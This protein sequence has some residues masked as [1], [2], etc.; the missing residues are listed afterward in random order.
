MNI[1]Y[2]I[3]KINEALQN[4]RNATGINI[5]MVKK[6]FSNI[7]PISYPNNSYCGAVQK[8]KNGAKRCFFSDNELY[9][10]CK[11]SRKMEMHVCHAGLIDVVVPIIYKN[12]IISYIILGQMK[13]DADFASV[14]NY[15]R[16]LD[17]DPD[18]MEKNYNSLYLFNEEKI[19][20]IAAVA[21]ML[22]KYILLENMLIPNTNPELQKAVDYINENLENP[23]KIKDI[24]KVSNLSKS[25]LY[26]RFH[27]NFNCTVIDYV[28]EKRVE[29][30]AEM[31]ERT[32]LSME[33]ISQKLGFSSKSYFSKIFK[34]K[35]G[36]SPIQ[37]RK[38]IKVMRKI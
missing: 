14:R 6:D 31:I 28:I 33:N 35:M 37:Y 23:I 18:E 24:T 15:L 9:E 11:N 36:V 19:N 2:N 22:A 8:C 34:K 21:E 29:K 20:S 26:K 3:D 32:S 27:D 25:V 4:F 7:N 38:N 10:K 12:E 17:T 1:S 16:N 13:K 5:K 30:A